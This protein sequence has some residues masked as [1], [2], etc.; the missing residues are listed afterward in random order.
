MQRIHLIT[1][2]QVSVRAVIIRPA[3]DLPNLITVGISIAFP[4]MLMMHPQ[5]ILIG[6]AQLAIRRSAGVALHK[7]MKDLRIAFPAI[8]TMLHRHI[9]QNNAQ[10]A[11]LPHQAGK[12]TALA[13]QDTPIAGLV[14]QQM[15]Q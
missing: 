15:R 11:T 2:I 3:G 12:I 8:Q 7:P 9:F 6:S 1:I 10:T 5:I 4:A 13:T 14:T